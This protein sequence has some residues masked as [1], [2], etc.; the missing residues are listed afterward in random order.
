MT[1]DSV[2]KINPLIETSVLSLS[3][4]LLVSFF[5]FSTSVFKSDLFCS[6]DSCLYSN[7]PLP[8]DDFSSKNPKC[9]PRKL[10]K[11][12]TSTQNPTLTQ[13]SNSYVFSSISSDSNMPN[14]APVSSILDSISKLH[15]LI[16]KLLSSTNYREFSENHRIRLKLFGSSIDYNFILFC[17]SELADILWSSHQLNN[18]SQNN[19]SLKSCLLNFILELK[20]FLALHSIRS[21]ISIPDSTNKVS[22][23]SLRNSKKRPFSDTKIALSLDKSSFLNSCD[24][25]FNTL[26][27]KNLTRRAGKSLWLNS[28]QLSHYDSSLESRLHIDLNNPFSENTFEKISEITSSDFAHE[29]L[30]VLPSFFSQDH[31]NHVLSLNNNTNDSFVS[32]PTSIPSNNFDPISFVSTPTSIPSNTF[33]P[34]SHSINCKF[35]STSPLRQATTPPLQLGDNASQKVICSTR[36]IKNALDGDLTCG[37]RPRRNRGFSTTQ[38]SDAIHN[39]PTSTPIAGIKKRHSFNHSSPQ[40][41][42]EHNDKTNSFYKDD[43]DDEQDFSSVNDDNEDPYI[44][45]STN[46]SPNIKFSR[47]DINLSKNRMDPRSIADTDVDPKPFSKFSP[48]HNFFYN[49]ALSNSP[50]ATSPKSEL[51]TFQVPNSS[52]L[53]PP[54]GSLLSTPKNQ[55]GLSALLSVQAAKKYVGN[56]YLGDTEGGGRKHRSRNK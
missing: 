48:D 35:N 26:S 6:I 30:S 49:G 18:N 15:S 41:I 3:N 27:I 52:N 56:F 28:P 47:I 11:S 55:T 45:S 14:S 38:S 51:A 1:K 39:S 20:T 36:Y 46:I 43:S 5:E 4:S 22:R 50:C 34:S 23:Y 9:R 33:D 13:N 21:M 31:P 32:T 25:I 12:N 54:Q 37:G 53:F 29:L 24:L 44:A 8:L 19:S 42:F 7:L 40:S 2:L 17:A 10:H 16:S